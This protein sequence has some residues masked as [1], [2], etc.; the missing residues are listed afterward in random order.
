VNHEAQVRG[1]HAVLRIEVAAL[2]ALG[3]LDLF[4][5]GE[6]R[7]T[8]GLLEEQLQRLQVTGLLVP[9][10][11]LDGAAIRMQALDL[12]PL[13]LPTADAASESMLLLG[14]AVRG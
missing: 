12:A 6:Q 5:G 1:D 10:V 2:Y 3:E 13:G 7:V 11:L 4:S 14:L 9:L 8:C